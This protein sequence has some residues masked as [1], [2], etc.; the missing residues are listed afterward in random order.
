MSSINFISTKSLKNILFLFAY[1]IFIVISI[2][3]AEKA[4]LY[5]GELDIYLPHYLG[6]KSFLSIIFDPLCE[7]DLTG[8][9]FRGREIGN[10]FNFIDAKL[11]VMSFKFHN[12]AFISS[13]Y[14]LSLLF[15]IALTIWAT[16]YKNRTT[17][18]LLLVVLLSSPPVIFG[19]L[20]YRTNKIIAA[21]AILGTVLL[22]NLIRKEPKKIYYAYLFLFSLLASFADEQGF[23]LVLL[24][25]FFDYLKNFKRPFCI[26]FSQKILIASILV[27][28][29]YRSFIGPY[30]FRLI[31]G[32]NPSTPDVGLEGLLN[33]GN[34][35]NSLK[36]LI[37]Y[38]SYLFGNLGLTFS[39]IL[40][41]LAIILVTLGKL[42]HAGIPIVL[43]YKKALPLLFL[44][45]GLTLIIHVM[46]L[47]HP[48]I[49]WPDIIS[50]YSL[51]I[52]FFLFGITCVSIEQPIRDQNMLKNLHLILTVFIIFN[53]ISW[54][55]SFNKITNGHIKVF[56]VADTVIR[57]VYADPAT[58]SK[59]LS[60]ISIHGETPGK[61][62]DMELGARGVEAIKES[63]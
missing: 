16:K 18:Q 23:V 37:K 1:L 3:F 10:A 32:I 33:V 6:G 62:S 4:N 45:S 44:A 35:Y 15:V 57:A 20:F 31:N 40:L 29:S 42:K 56:R 24:I 5:H 26:D 48:A 34:F 39:A 8:K 58:S 53:V 14:Y 30:F 63:L 61:I 43:K 27:T 9:T 22:I 21:T 51:P 46:T 13:V 41:T 25:L 50:Y 36:L 2:I 59:L 52:V 60:E 17:I 11:L 7:L 12:A 55:S 54:Q 38:A 19:G 47:K 49:F 28:L